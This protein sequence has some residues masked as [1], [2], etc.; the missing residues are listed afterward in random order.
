MQNELQ[1]LKPKLLKTSD[2]TEKLMIKIEQ[3]TMNIEA[4][5]EVF[6]VAMRQ[7]FVSFIIN[8]AS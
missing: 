6:D 4:A 7:Q 8:F 3:N 1:I 5:K 2:A